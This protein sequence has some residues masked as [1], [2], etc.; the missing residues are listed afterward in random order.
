MS[1][2]E[3][4]AVTRDDVRGLV[5]LEDS[6]DEENECVIMG[7]SEEEN[8]NRRGDWDDSFV[9]DRR[10][11]GECDDVIL[12][13]VNENEM[14]RNLIRTPQREIR[15]SSIEKF[16]SQVNEFPTIVN[17]I[18]SPIEKSQTPITSPISSPHNMESQITALK[19]PS[20]C[21]KMSPTKKR[22][23]SLCFCQKEFPNDKLI[24]CL[25]CFE[26]YHSRCVG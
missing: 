21:E 1:W 15:P 18:P 11:S 16:P 5:V 8:G 23:I 4:N 26:F 10:E 14:K 9:K 20:S 6:E 13:S 12:D 22:K 24:Q 2:S 3:S 7:E 19:R 17:D 25:T